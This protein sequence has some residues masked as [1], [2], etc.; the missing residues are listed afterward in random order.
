MD[1]DDEMTVAGCSTDRLLL[2]GGGVT[3]LVVAGG[4]DRAPARSFVGA[5]AAE[6]GEQLRWR[7]V[8]E[9]DLAATGGRDEVPVAGGA[10]GGA[11]FRG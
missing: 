7:L 9:H 6:R 5:V 8:P 11:P 10:A 4:V 2:L 3:R 1:D